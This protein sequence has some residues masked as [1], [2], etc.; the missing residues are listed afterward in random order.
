MAELI[1]Q[2]EEAS[3]NIEPADVDKMNAPI[4]HLEVREALGEAEQ[5]SDWGIETVLI[6]SYK[7]HVSIRRVNDVDVLSKLPE[8]PRSVSPQST[9]DAFK[10]A[11]LAKYPE[12]RIDPQDRSFKVLFPSFGLHVDVVPARLADDVLEIPDRRD[13][14]TDESE[15]GWVRTNPEEL[16]R[17]TTEQNDASGGMYVPIVKL[18]RQTRRTRVGVGM[19]PGGFLFEILTYHAFANGLDGDNLP[20]LYVSAMESTAALLENV[21][22][23]DPVEDPT[24]PGAHISVR[25]TNGEWEAAADRWSEAATD[26]GTALKEKDVCEAAKL[27]RALL[28]TNGDDEVVFPM[29]AAC[30]ED[31][32]RKTIAAITPG[33]RSLPEGDRDRP[34]A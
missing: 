10:A 24:M 28:G 12:D 21:I 18:I 19:R 25:A 5:L 32:N 9:L 33:D 1:T 8:L 15:R 14:D 23:G 17:L 16:T 4:A 2:F 29:P 3:Q 20:Q 22:A 6:G 27:Y 13:Q 26:A 30:D 7:R 34:F 31:G 11:L